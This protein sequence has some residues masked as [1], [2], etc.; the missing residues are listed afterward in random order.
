M[1]RT[2]STVGLLILTLAG[3]AADST[4]SRED[5]STSATRKKE[6]A[7]EPG[8]FKVYEDPS[9]ATD[10]DCDVHTKLE[11]TAGN[12]AILRRLVE[13]ACEL[14]VHPDERSYPVK[15]TSTSDCGAKN[16]EGERT[17]AEGKLHIVTISDRRGYACPATETFPLIV[18]KEEGEGAREVSY[19]SAAQVAPSE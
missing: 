13:G 9:R 10:P 11:L 6:R 19:F 15:W 18:V 17:D 4:A 16:Y 14:Y 1:T 3:C 7:I 12:V 2:A 5:E 8:A